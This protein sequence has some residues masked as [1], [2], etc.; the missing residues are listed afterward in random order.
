M[1][2]ID[3]PKQE[4]ELPPERQAIRD[5]CFHASGSF[6]EFPMAD[7]ESSIPRRFEKIVSQGP[8]QVAIKTEHRKWSYRDLDDAANRIASAVP[9]TAEDQTGRIGVLCD[10]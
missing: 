2:I 8:D 5:N 6:I 10:I 9:A 7:V 1:D 3:S 4:F